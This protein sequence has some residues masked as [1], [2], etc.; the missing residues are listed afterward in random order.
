MPQADQATINLLT[1]Y[2]DAMEAKDSAR[3]GSYYADTITLTFANAPTITGRDA[4]L[5]QMTTLLGKVKSLAHGG[6]YRSAPAPVGAG[7]DDRGR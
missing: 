2:F 3:L 1:D 4:V 7:A 6:G 5:E